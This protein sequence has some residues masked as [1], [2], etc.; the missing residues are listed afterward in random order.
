MTPVSQ[1]HDRAYQRFK[2]KHGR[3]AY[4]I[5]WDVE[6]YLRAQGGEL[7]VEDYD[8]AA[9]AIGVEIDALRVVIGHAVLC[10]ILVDADGVIFSPRILEDVEAYNRKLSKL[11]R[12]KEPPVTGPDTGARDGAEF[13]V[14]RQVGRKVD[15]YKEE[16]ADFPTALDS[17][18]CRA[19]WADWLEHKAS[20]KKPYKSI[21]AQSIKLSQLAEMGPQRFIAAIRNSIGNN[22][23]GI[24]EPDDFRAKSNG[25][26]APRLK[27][28]PFPEVQ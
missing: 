18:E 8:L 3:E 24:F 22:W 14:G 23:Q 16:I 27:P 12:G 25:H 21:K 4:G 9:T 6:L 7:P 11:K 10:G 19:A 26:A 20:I 28:R 5:L 2:V 17:P 1:L 15:I 13:A